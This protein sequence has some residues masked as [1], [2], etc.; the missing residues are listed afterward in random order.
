MKLITN[1]IKFNKLLI[2]SI[3]AITNILTF[4]MFSQEAINL[5]E[6]KIVADSDIENAKF[7]I[8]K[9]EFERSLKYTT[10]LQVAKNLKDGILLE[11][12]LE[13][14]PKNL[15]DQILL[16]RESIDFSCDLPKA[17]SKIL[18]RANELLSYDDIP[19]DHFEA[20]EKIKS[21]Q[22]EMAKLSKLVFFLIE[23]L[24]PGDIDCLVAE[25]NIQYLIK[26]PI[27][28][29]K[30][31][32]FERIKE[33]KLPKPNLDILARSILISFISCFKLIDLPIWYKGFNEDD[34]LN[35]LKCFVEEF[36]LQSI[37]DYSNKENIEFL[38]KLGITV[39]AKMLKVCFLGCVSGLRESTLIRLDELQL[40][41]YE[42]TKKASNK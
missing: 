30:K 5:E 4:S 37:F 29:I 20:V 40:F 31:I 7:Y 34:A 23:Y 14:L 8:P 11:N 12:D 28:G 32:F 36:N 41:L 15:K 22:D 17:L 35:N 18:K 1:K 2:V 24:T 42:L 25:D 9:N 6:S 27:N 13:R 10:L 38:E 3:L 33:L 26:T 16:M 39:S 19:K 21:L